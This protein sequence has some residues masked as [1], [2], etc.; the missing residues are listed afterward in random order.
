MH[1][2]QAPT[3]WIVSE[4]SGCWDQFFPG[5]TGWVLKLERSSGFGCPSGCCCQRGLRGVGSIMYACDVEGV[6]LL[7]QG[8]PLVGLRVERVTPTPYTLV[9]SL[10]SSPHQTGESKCT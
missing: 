1:M 3:F 4:G 6:G 9:N 8:F 2:R 5:V 10:V 7:L